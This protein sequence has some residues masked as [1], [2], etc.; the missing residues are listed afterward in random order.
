MRNKFDNSIDLQQS[1]G[2]IYKHTTNKNHSRMIFAS[3]SKLSLNKVVV[4]RP[5]ENVNLYIACLPLLSLN[6]I[7]IVGQNFVTTQVINHNIK[8]ISNCKSRDSAT[9]SLI[10]QTTNFYSE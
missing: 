7:E 8:R 6:V 9:M 1:N 5:K 3:L 10:Q 4:H 2:L